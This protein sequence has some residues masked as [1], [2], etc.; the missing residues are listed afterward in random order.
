[1]TTVTV[2]QSA[3]WLMTDDSACVGDVDMESTASANCRNPLT[4]TE[5]AGLLVCIPFQLQLSGN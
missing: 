1:L 2:A 3:R 5:L 4:F